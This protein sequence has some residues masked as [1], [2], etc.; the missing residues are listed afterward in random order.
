MPL[1]G[2]FAHSATT[3]GI[4]VRVASRFLPEQS[5]VRGHRFVWSY[6]VRIENHSTATVQLLR[7]HWIITDGNGRM[8]EVEGEGVV[9]AQPEI[10]PGGSF[11]YIS[12]CPLP[13]PNGDMKGSYYM[14]SSDGGFDVAVPQFLLAR[15]AAGAN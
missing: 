5:D 13:T 2:F 8:S 10:H 9:G 1:E 14:E 6:H 4:T 7:R 3:R 11:D 12:G 15:P